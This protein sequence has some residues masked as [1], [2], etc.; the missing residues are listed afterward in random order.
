MG[1]LLDL[2]R[3][4]LMAHR[5]DAV[6][7][8]E[9]TF[10]AFRLALERSADALETDLWLTKDRV[11]VCHHDRTLD[12]VTDCTGAIPEMPLAQVRQARVSGSYCGE[13]DESQ[14]SGERIPT[15]E[16]LLAFVPEDKGLALELKDPALAE[17]ESARQLVES[18]RPRIEAQT[19]M[20]LSFHTELLKA[21]QQADPQV[22][23]GKIGIF[24]PIPWFR[25]NGI[26][27]TWPAMR[28]NPLYM[29]IA[30]AL[31]LWVC[32]LDPTPEA[33]LPRYLS[34]DVDAVL[35]HDPAKTRKALND[36]RGTSPQ[37]RE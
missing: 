5:G 8:P 26:G 13:Y 18:I 16:E 37:E 15:L 22:W 30:R 7:A 1:N 28:L 23:V 21:A 12:R 32:P 9:N 31:D 35:T 2:P 4:L 29:P 19:V 25:G 34:M 3:P 17:P 20:L 11:L 33:R 14:H 24:S 27:T 6:H 10:A 36:Q